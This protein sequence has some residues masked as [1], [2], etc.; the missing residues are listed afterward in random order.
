MQLTIFT[1]YC[2][3]SLTYLAARPNKMSTVKEISEHYGISRNHL[4]KVI[5]RLA[6]LGY[7]ETTKGRSGGI[8]ITKDAANLRLGDLVTE[9]EPNLFLVECFNRETN[10]CNIIDSCQLKHYLF[11]ATQSF[12]N[13]LNKYTLAD[14]VRKSTLLYQGWPE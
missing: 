13:V 10:R 12:I 3:K 9:F 6:Q 1:D 2:L 7:I 8:K 5:H 4:V 11:E 14:A